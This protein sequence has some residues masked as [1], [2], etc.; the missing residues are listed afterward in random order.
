MRDETPPETCDVNAFS[1]VYSRESAFAAFETRESDAC[2]DTRSLVELSASETSKANQIRW[3]S[4]AI[5]MPEMTAWVEIIKYQS[6]VHDSCVAR[7]MCRVVAVV[8]VFDVKRASARMNES[9]L[10]PDA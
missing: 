1:C 9:Q 2:V 4:H 3:S 7:P 6:I 10:S 8:V 5:R